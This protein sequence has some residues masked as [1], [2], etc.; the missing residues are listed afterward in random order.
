MAGDSLGIANV[1]TT[2]STGAVTRN[3]GGVDTTSVTGF[4]VQSR[5]IVPEWGE[6]IRYWAFGNADNNSD[7]TITVFEQHQRAHVATG[8]N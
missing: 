1:G 4:A 5:W 2:D 7:S 6:I 8:R 3:I